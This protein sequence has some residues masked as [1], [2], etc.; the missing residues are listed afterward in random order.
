MG[1]VSLS[2]R[3]SYL[4][5][6]CITQQMLRLSNVSEPVGFLPRDFRLP[7]CVGAAGNIDRFGSADTSTWCGLGSVKTQVL[8]IQVSICETLLA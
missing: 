5:Q 6:Y 4:L 1:S 2:F 7:G 8:V 3:Y